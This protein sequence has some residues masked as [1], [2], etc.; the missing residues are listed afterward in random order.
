MKRSLTLVPALAVASVAMPKYAGYI[1]AVIMIAVIIFLHELGHFLAAK[2]MGMP[3]SEFALGLPFGPFIRFF[4]WKETA[5]GVRPFA[6]FGGYVKLAGYNPEEPDAEDPYGFLQQPFRKRMLFYSGG[7]LANM[8]TA[9][10]IFTAMGA[11]GGKSSPLLISEVLVGS[12]AAAAGVQSGDLITAIGELRFPGS[13]L[14]AFQPYIANHTGQQLQLTLDRGGQ[15]VTTKIVPVSDQ[16]S[17]KL[18]IRYSPTQRTFDPRQLTLKELAKAPYYGLR[19][20]ADLTWEV[21]RGLGQLVSRRASFK[22][23]GGPVTILKVASQQAQ[24]GWMGFFGFMA[25]ISINLAVLNALPIPFLDGG[26]MAI[27]VF[28]KLRQKELSIQIKE[29]ILT[30]GF[31]FLATLMIMVLAMD[32]LRMRH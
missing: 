23:V 20:T 13:K 30:A 16:G 14:A 31:F 26:H 1:S 19:S 18:G 22:Q 6:P 27:L 24:E 17:G 29:K 12:P 32:F 3:V 4:T 2:W 25:F 8:A 21:L 28:E 9:F 15:V 5:V 10:L 11:Q 7:V